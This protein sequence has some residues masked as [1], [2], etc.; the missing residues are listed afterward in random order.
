MQHLLDPIILNTMNKDKKQMTEKILNHALGIIFLLTGEEYI[1]V[2]K[3]YPHSSI[4]LLTGEVPIKCGDVAVYFS[5]EEW[6]YI[7]GHKKHYTDVVTDNQKSSEVPAQEHP[8][9]CDRNQNMAATN[10]VDKMEKHGNAV[11]QDPV[12]SDTGPANTQNKAP[13][14]VLIA[15]EEKKKT[16]DLNRNQHG[17]VHSV[18]YT[19]DSHNGV[20]TKHEMR[21]LK[22]NLLGAS[23]NA[24]CTSD[25]RMCMKRNILGDTHNALCTSDERMCMK[26]NIL[27]DTHNAICTSDERMCM[28]INKFGDSYSS[29]NTSEAVMRVKS[30]ILNPRSA[31]G[32][33]E[34]VM[35]RK[36][37]ILGGY[38]NAVCKSEEVMHTKR[39]IMVSSH[40]ATHTTDKMVFGNTRFCTEFQGRNYGVPHNEQKPF[41]KVIL[42]PFSVPCP[43]GYKTQDLREQFVAGSNDGVSY[44]K[45]MVNDHQAKLKD[46]KPYKYEVQRQLSPKCRDSEEKPHKCNVCGKQF[47]TLSKASS[48]SRIHN[49]P[50]VCPECGKGFPFRS[51]L[52][53]HLRTHTKVTQHAC[54]E[55]GK[56][57]DKRTLLEKHFRTHTQEKPYVCPECGRCFSQRSCMETHYRIHTKEKPYSCRECG[58]CFAQRGHRNMHQR[59]HTGEKPFPCPECGKCFT[60]RIHLDVHYRVHSGERPYPCPECGKSFTTKAN[61]DAHLKTHALLNP[62]DP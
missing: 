62:C 48:H 23:H 19:G 12:G 27:G 16:E 45:S 47:P 54:P 46:E 50:F 59:I 18:F 8:G 10:D 21:P 28:K 55:C 61:M 37:N 14:N 56:Y 17:K 41:G 20:C 6:E 38:T 29:M 4:Q 35:H 51:N 9:L 52:N 49:K 5:M 32:T 33:S 22:K 2:K 60:Q 40:N 53:K 42:T 1:I 7:E 34:E 26:R 15:K 36:N 57:F 31:L 11:Q 44:I 43:R 24:V 25:E 30:K 39:D 58:K 13:E 3:N